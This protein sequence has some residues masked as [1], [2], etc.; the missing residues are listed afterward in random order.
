L[1][2]M[3]QSDMSCF[4][5]L[6]SIRNSEVENIYRAFWD[7]LEKDG[8]PFTCHWGQTHGLDE[9]RLRKYFGAN[10][11]LWK[12]ARDQLLPSAEARRVFQSAILGEVGLL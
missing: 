5:E 10:V 11:G 6:P 8:L 1:L 7:A 2:G 12:T 4:I 9:T 3:N